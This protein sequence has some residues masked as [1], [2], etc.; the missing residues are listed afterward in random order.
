M[1]TKSSIQLMIESINI[2]N[3]IKES[4][5]NLMNKYNIKDNIFIYTDSLQEATRGYFS[6]LLES[7]KL[8]DIL[9]KYTLESQKGL[10]GIRVI[11]NNEYQLGRI[12]NFLSE[13]DKEYKIL[14]IDSEINVR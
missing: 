13:C 6:I 7:N 2:R 9:E 3:N 8:D 14:D 12:Y 4:M 11:N 5:N 1:N 10:C